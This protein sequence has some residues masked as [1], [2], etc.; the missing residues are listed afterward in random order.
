MKSF[1]K[2]VLVACPRCDG[3]VEAQ[4]EFHEGERSTRYYPGS[5]PEAELAG[6][7]GC[8][9][10]GTSDWSAAELAE[11]ESDYEE[12]AWDAISIEEWPVPF[13]EG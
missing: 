6:L 8:P 2:A 1:T 10:C 9:D 3:D 4:F 5:P 7:G 13:R 11:I 12:E